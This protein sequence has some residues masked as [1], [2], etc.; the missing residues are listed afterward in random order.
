MTH[1]AACSFSVASRDGYK[2][3]GKERDSESGLDNF[4]FRYFGYSLGRFMSPDDDSAQEPSNP[5]SWNLYSY[6]MNRPM[7]GWPSIRAK[8]VSRAKISWAVP[9]HRILCQR[10]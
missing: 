10:G 2:F 5:Q 8:A 1:S 6:V 4:D 3:T 7:D 9:R